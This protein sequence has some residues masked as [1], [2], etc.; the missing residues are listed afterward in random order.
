MDESVAIVVC[1]MGLMLFAGETAM[2]DGTKHGYALKLEWTGNDGAGTEGYRS[3]RREYRLTAAGKVLIEGSSDPTFRGDRT[4]WNP[5][6]ML[7]AALSACHMLSYLHECA[8]NGVVVTA[9]EDDAVGEMVEDSL[10]AKFQ[11]VVLRPRVTV[12]DVGMKGKADEL[13]HAAHE[14]CFIARSV[15]FLVECEAGVTA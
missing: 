5:E 3:Y 2:R 14:K 1:R 4:K 8:V 9:Y 7:L 6:E 15:N 12:A 13:H 11:R 10:S